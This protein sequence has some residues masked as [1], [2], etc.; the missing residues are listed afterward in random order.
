MA[1]V[2][3]FHHALG[4]TDWIRGFAD[5]LRD[6]GHTVHSPDL[7]DGRTFDS[8]EDGMAYAEEIGFPT[9]I[10]ERGRAAVD[11]LPGDIVYVGFSLGVMPAQSFAQ[12]RAGARGARCSPTRRFPW[13]VGRRLAED[14]A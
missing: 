12:T 6:A 11:S 8:I 10:L 14:V 1:E 2:V 9:A 7:F 3:V 4:R 13:A 5:A